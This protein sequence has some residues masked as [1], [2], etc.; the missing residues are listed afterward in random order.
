[1]TVEVVRC[2]WMGRGGGGGR[3]LDRRTVC[4]ARTPLNNQTRWWNLLLA[5]KNQE[6]WS[7]VGENGWTRL[8]WSRK[9]QRK[10]WGL[11]RWCVYGGA[12]GRTMGRSYSRKWVRIRPMINS[13]CHSNRIE[14]KAR[15]RATN[16]GVVGR[17]TERPDGFWIY[18]ASWTKQH[19]GLRPNSP[20]AFCINK[21]EERQVKKPMNN[22][23]KKTLKWAHKQDAHFQNQGLFK[24]RFLF[25]S[26]WEQMKNSSKTVLKLKIQV[27]M[28][29]KTKITEQCPP[30]KQCPNNGATRGAQKN[31]PITEPPFF[32]L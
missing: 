16:S 28:N 15:A 32:S 13:L 20:G 29:K 3:A 22:N 18:W 24:F 1:M 5:K 2:S 30:T 7:G 12:M 9:W 23:P 8:I 10:K 31:F 6:R 4:A 27:K 25:P 17:Y 19:T 26:C 11:N 14:T 21:K